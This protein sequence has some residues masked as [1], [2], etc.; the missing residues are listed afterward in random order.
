MSSLYSLEY[1]E[2]LSGGNREFMGQLVAVFISTVPESIDLMNKHYQEQAYND[3]GL[4]AHKLKSSIATVQIPELIEDVKTIEAIGKS[5][6]GI[7][8]LPALMEKLN[9]ILPRAIEELKSDF[10][11]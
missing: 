2:T 11:L 1:L 8:Q 9:D 10:N 5:A 3:L 4:E 7:E 6:S